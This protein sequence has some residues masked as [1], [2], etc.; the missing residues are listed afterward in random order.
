MVSTK[1]EIREIERGYENFRRN[2]GG[3][4]TSI[5]HLV[6][7]F[8]FDSAN[9]TM[10][11]VYDEG[12]TR[13]WKEG[14]LIP[15]LYVVRTESGEG[16]SPEGQY[17]VDYASLTFLVSDFRKAGIVNPED[18]HAHEDDRFLFRSRLFSVDTFNV[19]GHFPNENVT[20]AVS[21]AQ[22]R[23]DENVLDTTGQFSGYIPE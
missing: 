3:G 18:N 20:I 13:R 2:E 16:T 11:S 7:W 14:V 5:G 23:E 21:G 8:E 4:A 10:H 17:Q 6:R 1:R 12:P 19:F 22:V 15:V 9:T